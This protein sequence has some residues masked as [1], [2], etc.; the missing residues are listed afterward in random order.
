MLFQLGNFRL[1]SGKSSG[2]KIE[3]DSLTEEDWE[4]LALIA[5]EA[6][7]PFGRVEGVPRGGIPFANAL[8]KYI[9]PN[10]NVLLLAEDVITTGG[11]LE[12]FRAGR[13]AIGVAVFARGH[14]PLWVKP[15]FVLG[16]LYNGT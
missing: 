4:A 7:P 16:K 8:V 5:S 10:C 14:W 12:R 3:C 9:I 1:R 15:L 11:S 13:E 6:L 2:W